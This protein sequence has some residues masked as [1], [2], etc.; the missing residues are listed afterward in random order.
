MQVLAGSNYFLTC[1]LQAVGLNDSDELVNVLEE[2]D[3][4]D[5]SGL[6][7]LDLSGFSSDSTANLTDLAVD[8]ADRPVSTLSF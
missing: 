2:H 3:D 4:F 5:V 8:T 1:Y 7:D 6:S